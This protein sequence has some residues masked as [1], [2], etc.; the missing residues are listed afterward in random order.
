MDKGRGA[1]GCLC[2][3]VLFSSDRGRGGGGGRFRQDGDGRHPCRR[4][5]MRLRSWRTATPSRSGAK[6]SSSCSGAM[7]SPRCGPGAL[8]SAGG[9]AVLLGSSAE[10]V[11][12]CWAP[13]LFSATCTV[14]WNAGWSLCARLHSQPLPPKRPPP[15]SRWCGC[16]SCPRRLPPGRS[17]WIRRGGKGMEEN[18]ARAWPHTS[19]RRGQLLRTP[20]GAGP[21][22]GPSV[23]ARPLQKA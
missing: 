15:W 18:P 21:P 23:R 1:A 19:L 11:S 14:D 13:R 4:W 3:L 2:F 16:P 17:C 9:L 22:D 8:G 6:K 10:A 5:R 20:H 12:M 7:G